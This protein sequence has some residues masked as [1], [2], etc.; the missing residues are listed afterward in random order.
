MPKLRSMTDAAVL[1]LKAP[2]QG[3]IDYFDSSFPGLVLRVSC[4]GRK[5]WCYCYRFDGKPRRMT[6]DLYPAM[7]VSAAHDA[8]RQARDSVAAGFDPAKPAP[9]PAVD[10]GSIFEEWMRRDQ[11]QHRSARDT[12]KRIER[13]VLSLWAHRKIDDIGRR[14]VLDALDRVV[15]RGHVIS[16]NRLHTHLHRMF[17][18]SIERGILD[19]NPVT[20]LPKPGEE[21]R[22]DRVL[23]DSELVKVWK[24]AERLGYP[25]GPCLQLL[26]LTGARRQE[27]A[28]L[29]WS[30]IADGSINLSGTRTKNG[31]AHVI[32]LSSFGR[33]IL[34]STPRKGA[35]VFTIVG[36]HGLRHWT[37][38][39]ADLDDYAAVT[40][41][42]VVHDLRRTVAT[43]LQKLGVRLE[44]TESVLGHTS[45][46][47]GGIVGIYQRHDYADE[48]RSALEAWGARVTALIEGREGLFP[49]L[50]KSDRFSSVRS[51]LATGN[52]G[53]PL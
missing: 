27:I 49:K 36:S 14:D 19:K 38:A 12:R 13:E 43:G 2:A 47:R 46:S 31:E 32:P 33:S 41:P 28:E 7:R 24:A 11:E 22:R 37:R 35:F 10:F 15:D 48:K 21:T 26:V 39:K 3:Q 5:T 6:L 30:E 8:W 50:C 45:G 4:G 29:R 20:G 53:L 44:V 18:W 17:Q 23:S 16:A 52:L 1:R 9:A 25:Y 51:F 34:E 42:Y 40:E